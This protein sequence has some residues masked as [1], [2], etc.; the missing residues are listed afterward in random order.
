MEGTCE[1]LWLK[2]LLVEPQLIP[3]KSISLRCDN[4]DNV[5]LSHNPTFHSRFKHFDIH[6]HFIWEKVEEEAIEV[7]YIFLLINNLLTF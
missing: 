7:C 2:R 3:S 5:Q 1:A 4:L 6:L